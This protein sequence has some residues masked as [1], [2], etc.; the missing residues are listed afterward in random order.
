MKHD[1]HSKLILCFK[2]SNQRIV[3]K[4]KFETTWKLTRLWNPTIHQMHFQAPLVNHNN[5]GLHM[6]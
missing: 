4:Y 2:L 6:V 1:R 3:G 5:K